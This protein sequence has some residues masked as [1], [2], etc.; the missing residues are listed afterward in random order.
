MDLN[1]CGIYN[2]PVL[3]RKH[4]RDG[5]LKTF[6]ERRQID[7]EKLMAQKSAS[8]WAALQTVCYLLLHL[9]QRAKALRYK[10]KYL[11]INYLQPFKKFQSVTYKPASSLKKV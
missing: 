6:H 5:V 10:Y 8:Q 9:R 1:H 3:L 7:Y 11:I 4:K 2:D